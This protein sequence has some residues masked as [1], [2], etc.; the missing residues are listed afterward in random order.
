MTSFWEVGPKNKVFSRSCLASKKWFT[1]LSNPA[2]HHPSSVFDVLVF[3][4]LASFPY[5][6]SGKAFIFVS[7][8]NFTIFLYPR[9]TRE[10]LFWLLF[11]ENVVDSGSFILAASIKML[12]FKLSNVCSMSVHIFST[13]SFMFPRPQTQKAR[14]K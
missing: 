8:T 1:V 9:N 2:Y 10:V 14:T 4:L 12:L 7:L 11:E 3:F 5:R 6:K 13:I